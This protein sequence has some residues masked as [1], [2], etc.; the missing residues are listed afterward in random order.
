MTR[1]LST[2]I[3]L[4]SLSSA[5]TTGA[6]SGPEHGG[7]AATAGA[8]AGAM[9]TAHDADAAIDASTSRVPL[10]AQVCPAGPFGDPLPPQGPQRTATIVAGN[11][12]G[13]VF[14][15]GPLWLAEQGVLLFSDMN[16]GA[17]DQANGPPARI[18]R[19]T[20]P[21]TFDVFQEH[22]NSNGLALDLEGDVLA[23]THDTQTLSRYDRTSAARTTLSAL[24]YDGKRF[25]SPNDLTVRSDGTVYF[26]D[27]DWQR[28]GRESI[29]STNVYRLTPAARVELVTSA[30][31]K[32]NGIALSPDEG[33]LYVGSSGPDIVA[34]TVSE[35]G[36]TSGGGVFVSAGGGTDGLTV[37]CAGNLY[38]TG[39]SQVQVWNAAGDKLGD[40]AVPEGTS[41]VAFGGAD[42]KTLYITAQN[43]LYAIQLLVPGLPY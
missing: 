6:N 42:R 18:R 11:Q 35:D 40:I 9:P 22:G 5:C 25:N 12:D 2:L 43:S 27:P 30:L 19:L 23:C 28:A 16:F 32:P 1:A 36:S 15:E 34:F 39:G 38:A 26:T 13:F 31:D 33:T 17:T 10:A 37:D 29:G 7:A 4:S 8:T 3:V 14:L 20:P 41:N 24:G 21:S